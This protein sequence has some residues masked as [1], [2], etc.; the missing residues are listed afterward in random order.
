MSAYHRVS[1][2]DAYGCRD[3]KKNVNTK[4][5]YHTKTSFFIIIMSNAQDLLSILGGA[6]SGRTPAANR[7]STTGGATETSILSFKAGKMITT[8]KPNGKYLVEPDARRGELHVVWTTTPASG[9]NA[10]AA[11]V[12]GGH[13]KLEWKDRRTKTTVNTIPVFP[14]DDATFE[15][16]ETGREGDRVYLLQ[17]GGATRHFFW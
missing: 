6:S 8:L 3:D 7:A 5:Y 15:R 9:A 2:R 4:Y 16:V 1:S 14:E 12:A 10:A 11:L 13:L 17:C